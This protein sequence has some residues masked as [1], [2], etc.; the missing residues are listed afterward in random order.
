M[1]RR[2][3]ALLVLFALIV[4]CGGAYTWWWYRLAGGIREGVDR[5]A[6]LRR[7]DGWTVSHG[8]IETSGY[9]GPIRVRVAAPRLIRPDGASWQAAALTAW[10]SPLDPRG[11]TV[12]LAGS[13]EFGPVPTTVEI[14]E[15][16]VA[17]TTSRGG[18]LDSAVLRLR[19]VA[20]SAEGR[21]LNIE[22]LQLATNG[23]PAE[24]T[25]R[26]DGAAQGVTPPARPSPILAARIAS[27]T[28]RGRLVGSL[29]RADVAGL[30]AWREA[31]GTVEIEHLAIDWAP[32]GVAAN[33]TAALDERMQPVMAASAQ[34]R[35]FLEAVDALVQAGAVGDKDARTAKMVLTLIAKPQNGGGPPIIEVP[36]TVQDGTFTMGP[37]VLAKVPEIRWVR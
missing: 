21:R 5:W 26:F 23:N 14:A 33:G 36:L 15:G 11:V 6:E 31:G 20:A 3:L 2:L 29:P 7:L 17:L 35:G 12:D 24:G 19:Q 8:G 28:L 18:A 27:L 1:S 10:V 16:G 25:L 34:V 22:A 13:H 37:A 32:I 9:P 4:A 30:D